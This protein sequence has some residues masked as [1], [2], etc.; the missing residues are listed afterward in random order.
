[1]VISILTNTYSFVY[2][3]GYIGIFITSLLGAASLFIFP[4]PTSTLPFVFGGVL[5]PFLVGIFAACGATI[6]EVT[7]YIM[8]LG[9]KE[10]LEKKYSKKLEKVRET[11]ERY[12]SFYWIIITVLTPLP[13]DV[14]GIFCGMIKYDLRKFL[15]GVFIGKLILSLTLAYAGHYSVTWVLDF[16]GIQLL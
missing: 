16:F 3:W 4:L 7:S 15:L 1:M 11:F 5:N 10:L 12:G 13:T 6:G 14:A 9:S 2:K 8:G